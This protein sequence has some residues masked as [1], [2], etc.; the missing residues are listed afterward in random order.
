M[1]KTLKYLLDCG[2]S[3]KELHGLKP[4]KK[5]LL[6]AKYV[7]YNGTIPD[8]NNSISRE[9]LN[10]FIDLDKKTLLS[11]G[12]TL[13]KIISEF[14]MSRRSDIDEHTITIC[15]LPAVKF[16]KTPE[17]R[18]IRYKVL[19][20]AGNRCSACGRSPK[21]GVIIHVDHILPRSIFPEKA[22]DLNN[23]QVL[24]EDCNIGKS[25]KYTRDWR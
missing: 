1:D 20:T 8:I 12:I 4:R 14:L 25:N 13:E 18:N 10:R 22:L 5:I 9:F 17:W 16:Y 24:C 2:Y 6:I 11:F 7:G 3:T 15:N 23:L 21:E 19:E